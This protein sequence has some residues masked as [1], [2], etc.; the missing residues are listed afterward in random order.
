M[1]LTRN[2]PLISAAKGAG[3]KLPRTPSEEAGGKFNA[4]IENRANHEQCRDILDDYPY[5]RKETEQMSDNY[6]RNREG[7]IIGRWDGNWLRDGT[8]KLVA[9]YDEA[10]NRSRDRNGKI[11][12][13]GDQRMRELGNEEWSE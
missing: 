8:G 2:P 12:G 5:E 13:S 9:R 10:N 3:S 11:V 1:V 6:I 4:T 7:K